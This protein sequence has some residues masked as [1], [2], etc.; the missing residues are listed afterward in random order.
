MLDERHLFARYN[1]ANERLK[2]QYRE[3]LREVGGFPEKSLKV[4]FQNILRCER[5][6]DYANIT[7]FDKNVAMTLKQAVRALPL[8]QSTII[9]TLGQYQKLLCWVRELPRHRHQF[10][11]HDIHYLNINRNEKKS[12]RAKRMQQFPKPK[13]LVDTIVSMPSDSVKDKRNRA[14]IVVLALTGLRDGTLIHL[15]LKHLNIEARYLVIDPQEVPVKCG[16]YHVIALII[17]DERLLDILQD[18]VI[19]LKKEYHFRDDDPLFPKLMTEHCNHH[20]THGDFS[21]QFLAD[22]QIVQRLCKQVFLKH[23]G[24]AYTPHSIRHSLA[25]LSKKLATNPQ[26]LKALSQNLGHK[27]TMHMMETYGQIDHHRQLEIIQTEMMPR[28]KS[29][30]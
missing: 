7:D 14:M 23:L 15:R 24:K 27:T 5:I 11:H 22:A 29:I 17:L 3:Y 30:L 18:Y 26:E 13:E 20:F 10:T 8:A 19:M 25:Y 12:L 2:Y 21:N 9:A 6:L 28:L 16:S 1:P 4:M